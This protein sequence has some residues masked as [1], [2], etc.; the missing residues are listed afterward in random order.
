MSS[1]QLQK[2]KQTAI[3]FY[4]LMFND[5][6]PR[7]AIEKYTGDQYIQHNPH[8]PDGKEGFIEYF[9]KIAR[10]YPDKKLHV[11]R[12]IAEEN[13]VVLHTFQ[14][15]PTDEDYVTMDIFRFNEKGKIVEHWDV[16]QAMP[17]E[18]AHDNGMF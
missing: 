4:E 10:D 12:A 16:L 1:D 5:D 2:N 17:Q 8:V 13:L 7:G 6:D 14:E 11:K 15:W 3:A 9:E 18:F